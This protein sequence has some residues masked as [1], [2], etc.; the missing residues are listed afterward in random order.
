MKRIILGLLLAALL[1]PG[2][3]AQAQGNNGNGNGGR[4]L[5]TKSLQGLDFGM[6][7]PGVPLTV[8]RSDPVSAGQLEV[9]GPKFSEVLISFIL[10]DAMRGP[11]G[12]AIPL[13]FGPG[14]AGYSLSLSIDDQIGFDPL[15][16]TLVSL[17]QRGRARVFLGGTA[18]P[19]STAAAGSYAGEIVLTVSYVG[20]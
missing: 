2:A 14:S 20:N 17:P 15:V 4:P 11:A 5:R 13:T 7:I 8:Q 10:S 1:L 12:S 9:S 18:S 16:P 6:V 3:A 19:P